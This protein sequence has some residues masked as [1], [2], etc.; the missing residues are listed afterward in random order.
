M[1]QEEGHVTARQ[2][3][4]T[5]FVSRTEGE[6]HRRWGE[7]VRRFAPYVHAVARVHGLSEQDCEWVFEEV[8][9]EA[10]TVIGAPADD[11]ALRAG[12][13]ELTERIAEDRHRAS[14]DALTAPSEERLKCL[15][16]A[17]A[18]H[19][20]TRGLPASQRELLRRRVVEGQDEATAAA[21]LGIAADSIAEQ[22]RAARTRLRYRLKRDRISA[23]P[24]RLRPH[25]RA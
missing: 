20:A 2:T 6:Q 19:D 25:D 17:L 9:A 22:L 15:R 23:S 11:Q 18:V 14:A 10:W 24:P 8:F 12:F 16:D 21:D 3:S 4:E 7:I 13:V 1:R 5:G